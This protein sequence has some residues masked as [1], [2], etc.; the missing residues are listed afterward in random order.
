MRTRLVTTA[1]VLGALAAAHGSAQAATATLDGKKTKKLTA[2]FSPAPQSHDSDLVTDA[3]KSNVDR[4]TCAAPRCE[5]LPFVFKPAKGVKGG[6]AFTVAW[7]V[8]GED[9][10]LYVAEI[11]KDGSSAGEVAHCGAS[12]GTS[13]RLQLSSSDF[14]PGKKYALIADFYRSTGGKVTA[15]VTF[16]GTTAIKT[17][18]PSTVDGVVPINCGL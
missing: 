13:E 5:R 4:T 15:T 11:A 16:P 1:V 8:P 17:T 12:A 2:T 14:K 3:A 18:A 9:I 6:M 10:D 7:S